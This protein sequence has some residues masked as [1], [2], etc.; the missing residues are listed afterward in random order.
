M[1][2]TWRAPWRKPI[3]I[4]DDPAALEALAAL[5]EDLWKK[6]WE[7]TRRAPGAEWYELRFRARY[8][9]FTPARGIAS[10]TGHVAARPSKRSR[11]A[12]SSVFPVTGQ[13]KNDW[14]GGEHWNASGP[15]QKVIHK[16]EWHRAR[17]EVSRGNG[18]QR[19]AARSAKRGFPVVNRLN[20]T[21][22]G[23]VQVVDQGVTQRQDRLRESAHPSFGA[24]APDLDHWEDSVFCSF[25]SLTGLEAPTAVKASRIRSRFRTAE[26]VQERDAGRP[27]HGQRARPV[28]IVILS[29]RSGI[30]ED[31]MVAPGVRAAR[32]VEP[33]GQPPL[34]LVQEH[35]A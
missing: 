13:G 23:V 8:L 20:P 3:Q 10:T 27:G 30:A 22:L 16:S 32:L 17:V 7:R 11:R 25:V 28:A 31:P 26:V 34:M 18:M 24:F 6:G 12:L 4:R 5:E 29:I 33:F 19:S 14:R 2:T 1:F 21:L 9:G 15:N 35:S